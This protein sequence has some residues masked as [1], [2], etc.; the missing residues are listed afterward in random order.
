MVVH[1]PQ[2]SCSSFLPNE[3]WKNRKDTHWEYKGLWGRLLKGK[4]KPNQKTRNSK[5]LLRQFCSQS[6]ADVLEVSTFFTLYLEK[7][8]QFCQC[9]PLPFFKIFTRTRRKN[10]SSP[11]HRGRRGGGKKKKKRGDRKED[12]QIRIC[13]TTMVEKCIS[14]YILVLLQY[15]SGSFTLDLWF[16][17]SVTT[18][19]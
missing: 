2:I 10:I 8:T 5:L 7:V 3:P 16:Y 14:G 17:G 15:Y 1:S 19:Y 6:N 9:S 18:K 12:F 4:I 13:D 11:C